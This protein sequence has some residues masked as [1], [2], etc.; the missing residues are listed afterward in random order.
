MTFEYPDL[1]AGAGAQRKEA[2]P[3]AQV[4]PETELA[5]LHR[6]EAMLADSY[7]QEKNRSFTEAGYGDH[8]ALHGEKLAEVKARIAELESKV[9]R[10]T[11]PESIP[12]FDPSDPRFD[13]PVY[14]DQGR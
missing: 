14:R 2:V 10:R 13:D 12:G 4:S 7:M 9:G 11:T 5:E 1:H 8:V 3:K 6:T